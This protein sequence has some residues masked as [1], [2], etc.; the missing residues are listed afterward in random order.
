MSRILQLAKLKLYILWQ[1]GNSTPRQLLSRPWR[2]PPR[3]VWSFLRRGYRTGWPREERT[4]RKQP[5]RVHAHAGPLYHPEN[6]HL[7]SYGWA[8]F[9][10]A[11]AG[12]PTSVPH[13]HKRNRVRADAKEARLVCTVLP[14]GRGRELA[15]GAPPRDFE[16]AREFGGRPAGSRS[17]RYSLSTLRL[18][19]RGA[20]G[21]AF[22]QTRCARSSSGHRPA[23]GTPQ[24]DRALPVGTE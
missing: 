12:F 8:S 23:S 20:S 17:G 10:Q 15:H 2:P 21:T 19:L 6:P 13:L 7:P 16:G 1:N 22:W 24:A 9:S 5:C 4:L 14:P 11:A 3:P 18:P